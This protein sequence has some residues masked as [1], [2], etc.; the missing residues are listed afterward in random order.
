MPPAAC[1]LSSLPEQPQVLPRT[2]T[3]FRPGVMHARAHHHRHT[4]V[5]V[6][7]RFRARAP[8]DVGILVLVPQLAVALLKV[9]QA[10]LEAAGRQD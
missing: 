10:R 7:T 5:Q 2:P 1:L 8:P 9:L 6:N 3:Q 4:A